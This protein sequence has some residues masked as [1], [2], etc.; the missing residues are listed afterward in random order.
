MSS[1]AEITDRSISSIRTLPPYLKKKSR[2]GGVP[3]S[4]HDLRLARELVSAHRPI[5]RPVF[6]SVLLSTVVTEVIAPR[7]SRS[8]EGLL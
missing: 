1:R 2:G 6:Q 3:S 7:R 8:R 4:T 5:G